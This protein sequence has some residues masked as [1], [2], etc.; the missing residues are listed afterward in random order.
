MTD[1]GWEAPCDRFSGLEPELHKRGIS[2]LL[3][4]IDLLETRL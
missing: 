1:N 4:Q 2:T 3:T